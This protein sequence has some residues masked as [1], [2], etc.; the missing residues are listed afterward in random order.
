M[1]TKKLKIVIAGD[2][3]SLRIRPPR[4]NAEELTYAEHLTNLLP[5]ST[6]HHLGVGAMSIRYQ[7]KDNDAFI[8]LFPD[9]YILN[10]GIVDA[11]TRSVPEYLFRF[12]NHEAANKWILIELLRKIVGFLELKYRK[13]LVKARGKTT[14]SSSGIFRE[15]YIKIIRRI[16]KETSAKII[17]LS[18]N[19]TNDRIENQL[20]GTSKNISLYNEIIREFCQR[21][22]C[23]FLNT[24][25]L[26]GNDELPD[27]IHFNAKGHKIIA[28]SL[29]NI[30]LNNQ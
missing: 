8:R 5:D 21:P 11:S 20:P 7:L 23:I 3:V 18:I 30:I 15:E 12:I 10:F 19:Q 25:S 27:G 29:K 16:E 6:I 28:E 1:T 24:A 9:F 2:S 13:I 4:E 17:C 14:W 22:R 26:V